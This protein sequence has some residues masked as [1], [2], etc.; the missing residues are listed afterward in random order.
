VDAATAMASDQPSGPVGL[1]GGLR[2]VALQLETPIMGGAVIGLSAIENA[3]LVLS[4]KGVGPYHPDVAALRVVI[5]HLTALEGDF[6]VRLRGAGL[7]YGASLNNESQSEQLQLTLY[8]CADALAAYSASKEIVADYASGKA[9]IS[10]IDLDGAKSSLTY[11]II[12]SAANKPAAVVSQWA[13][14][15]TGVQ[16]DYNSWLLSQVDDVSAADA[17][18]A[19]K[20]HL[21]P[22]FDSS[23]VLVASSPAG[24]ANE[25][26]MSL[27][28]AH[29]GEPLPV[30]PEEELSSKF[31][32]CGA[33][34][35]TAAGVVD[36]E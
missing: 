13:A 17:L 30:I 20:T 6:W 36:V 2:S 10:Q 5:E 4:A 3:Y 32:S 25:L 18:H 35:S 22:L 24:K 15:Y 16:A 28:E 29:A 19:L 9:S 21:T 12:S 23:A 11:S 33:K 8:R 34:V 26:A 27:G 7:T 31:G 14:G 1:L